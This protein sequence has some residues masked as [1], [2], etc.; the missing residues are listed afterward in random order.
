MIR[1]TVKIQLAVFGL[2]TLVTVAILSARYVG[3]TDKVLGGTY[4]VQADF[5]ESGGIFVGSEVTYRGV[6]VG[7]V[8]SL[9][10]IKDGVLVQARINRGVEV[11]KDT[12]V[13]VE[14]RSAVGEQYLDLQP[15]V[16][17]GPFL[18]PG[19][20]IPRS[21]TAY[22]VRVDILLQHIDNTVRSV[23]RNDLKITVDEFGKAFAD[24]GKDL[25]RLLDSGDAL[26]AAATAALPETIK[27]IDDGRI[28]LDTQRETS[29]QIKITAKNFADLAET[30]RDHDQDLR[31]I[32]DRGV[33]ASKELDGLIKDNQASLSQLFANFITIGN[34][35]TSRLGGIEQLLVTY[36]DVVAG[37]FTVVP[38][39]GTAHFGLVAHDDPPAC[40][41]GYEGTSK[42]LPT[43][44]EG[45]PPLNT[46]AGC[47]L[48][49]GS[50]SAVRGGQNAPR[51]SSGAASSYPMAFGSQPVSLGSSALAA[52]DQLVAVATPMAPAG[53]SGV[54]SWLW[55]MREAAQ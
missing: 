41:R 53:A 37:G 32:F 45:L 18:A 27:L 9:E 21:A 2:L 28:V 14:N 23:D 10:L 8:E 48:P 30:F 12:K 24:G 6:S 47:R 19:D 17:T 1:R 15:N 3:L 34:V 36:P 35:T 54:D 50:V 7:R 43:T 42:T 26:T 11:P 5:Q 39:D 13:V 55:M 4:V 16:S 46:A 38:G 29:S 22:P 49:R 51:P 33:V 44:T 31:L 25:A 20:T 40:T 52:N